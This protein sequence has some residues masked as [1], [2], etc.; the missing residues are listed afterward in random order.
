M[1]SLLL[2]I[3]NWIYNKVKLSIRN[4]I[5]ILFIP[6]LISIAFLFE[7]SGYPHQLS[8]FKAYLAFSLIPSFIGIYYSRNENEYNNSFKY[9]FLLMWFISI[10]SIIE[11]LI[12][13]ISP[14][15]I[16]LMHRYQG[17]SYTIAFTYSLNLYFILFNKKIKLYAFCK[18]KLYKY[19]SIALIILQVICLFIG[20]GRGAFIVVLFS[21]IIL[22]YFSIKHKTINK[23]M[24][25]LS[26]LCLFLIIFFIIIMLNMDNK[27]IRGF[28]RVF[29]YITSTGIDFTKTAGRDIIYALVIEGIKEKP[30]FGHGIFGQ[31]SYTKTGYPHNIFLEILLSG[32]ILYFVI[33]MLILYYIIKKLFYL[34]KNDVNKCLI[35]PLFSSAFIMILFSGTYLSNSLLWFLCSYVVC[36]KKNEIT[37][38]KR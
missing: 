25:F 10:I 27:N 7:N 16:Y 22:F 1:T 18:Y 2:I 23:K 13:F 34:A 6:L 12:Y 24:L 11:I 33:M 30:V 35:L 17:I 37:S 19:I 32:G 20:G 21:T 28:S 38:H 9:W 15:S 14:Y 5:F 8:I 26:V 36:Y 4:Y 31:F 3:H 29:S